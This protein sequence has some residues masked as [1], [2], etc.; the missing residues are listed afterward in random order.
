MTRQE[1]S[2]KCFKILDEIYEQALQ[3]LQEQKKAENIC[4]AILLLCKEYS[5]TT[6]TEGEHDK[7]KEYM[8]KHISEEERFHLSMFFIDMFE[9][10]GDDFEKFCLIVREL[11]EN[12]Q[13]DLTF[14]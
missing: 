6:L 2:D 13:L 1:I 8:D 5:L 10:C 4:T 14:N 7:L 12:K 3:V 9:K 11:E